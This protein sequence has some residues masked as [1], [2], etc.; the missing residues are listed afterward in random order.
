VLLMMTTM[1]P[2]F[3]V[4]VITVLAITMMGGYAT[5][6]VVGTLLYGVKPHDPGTMRR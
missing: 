6:R 1:E 4:L 2:Y 3:V 5:S